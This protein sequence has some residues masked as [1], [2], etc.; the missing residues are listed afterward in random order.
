M[1]ATT[2]LPLIILTLAVLGILAGIG[3]VWFQQKPGGAVSVTASV[4]NWS[5]GVPT[6][7]SVAATG[8]TYL[9]SDEFPLTKQMRFGL[10]AVPAGWHITESKGTGDESAVYNLESNDKRTVVKS[11]NTASSASTLYGDL[12]QC[13]NFLVE[14]FSSAGYL[15]EYK[16]AAPGTTKAAKYSTYTIVTEKGDGVELAR[17][18]FSYQDTKGVTHY[19]AALYRCGKTNTIAIVVN[20]TAGEAALNAALDVVV[21]ELILKGV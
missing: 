18:D 16:I 20:S 8:K 6:N 13:S 1:K 12:K 3:F 17:A 4:G 21:K 9:L 15:E 2:K 7:T 14:R 19:V 5:L 10:S 11:S